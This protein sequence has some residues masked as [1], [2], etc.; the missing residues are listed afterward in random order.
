MN[1][2]TV[3]LQIQYHEK[4]GD[5]QL[6][7]QPWNGTEMR[8]NF[9][10]EL[11]RRSGVL[12][13]DGATGNAVLVPT[14]PYVGDLADPANLRQ[15]LSLWL[16]VFGSNFTFGWSPLPDQMPRYDEQYHADNK[17][18]QGD[19]V[20]VEI[21]TVQAQII[22]QLANPEKCLV[23]GCSNG[24]LVRRSLDAGMDCFG[25][26][27][28]P[29]L[30]RIEFLEVKG[31]LR[32]GSLTAIPY[33]PQDGFDTLVAVDV[34]EHIPERDIPRMVEE[35]RRMDFKKL[36]LLINLNQFWYPGHITLRPLEWWADQWK[37]LF[38]LSRVESRFENLPPVYS[39]A[40]LYNQQ[41]TLW[42]RD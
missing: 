2:T 28:I 31:R 42:E 26:D 12:R 14:R 5:V 35:W 30:E 38:R 23:A 1:E 8:V 18:I 41:W 6:E 4:R 10:D 34:L 27:V 21:K 13:L 22:R 17:Y 25:F 7:F 40:G 3:T 24:E 37:P 33:L 9:R 11:Y 39:N 36:V 20:E 29:G 15:Y 32:E 16:R 19:P